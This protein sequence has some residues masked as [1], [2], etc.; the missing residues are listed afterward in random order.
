MNIIMTLFYFLPG[1]IY[2]NNQLFINAYRLLLIFH[3]ADVALH[4][5]YK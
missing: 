2:E 4:K 5:L 1:K 3:Y